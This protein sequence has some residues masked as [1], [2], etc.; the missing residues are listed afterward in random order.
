MSTGEIALLAWND[1]VGITRCRGLPADEI[2]G[3]MATG[4]GWAVAGQAMTPFGD[5]A[6]NP[7]GPTTEVRQIPVPE[8]LVRVDMWADAPP[9]HMYL[10]D[11]KNTDGTDWDCCT[12]GFMRHAMDDLRAETGLEFMAAFEHEF[13]LTGADLLDAGPFTL[14]AARNAAG[15]SA[16]LARALQEAGL[17]P[18]TVEP[19]YGV[20]QYEVTVAPAIGPTAGDRAILT[21]E[22]IREVARR[23]GMRACF[24]PKPTPTGV[25]NGSHVHFSFVDSEGRNATYDPAQATHASTVAQHFIGGVLRHID[26]LTALSA[27]SPVSYLRLGPQHWSCGYA[28]FGVQNRETA[29]RVCPSPEAD[30]AKRAR[31]FNLEFRPPDPTASPYIVLGA[32]IRAGLSGIRDEL[33]LPPVC[34]KDPAELTDAQRAELGITPLPGS[35][36][37]ALTALESDEVAMSWFPPNM[38]TSYFSV[39]RAELELT[40]SRT[41]EEI[42]EMY[43]QAY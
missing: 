1:Y 34:T 4:L 32:L 13:L 26:A 10:C 5:I 18:E 3:R 6:P 19:E 27:P 25:G 2:H 38:L 12:R 37:D 14:E 30:A 33:P 22:I 43:A 36:A 28:S 35:F 42:C 23:R 31:G 39:K 21:R 11:S 8:S 29:I 7:W 40:S 41:P 17:E 24:S 9:L 15:F 20:R 16:D